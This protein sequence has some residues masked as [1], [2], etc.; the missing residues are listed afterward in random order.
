MRSYTVYVKT[1]KQNILGQYLCLY[2]E[3]IS[4]DLLKGNLACY[5][6]DFKVHNSLNLNLLTEMCLSEHAH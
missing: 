3:A 6:H 4:M 5:P 1:Y 2:Y